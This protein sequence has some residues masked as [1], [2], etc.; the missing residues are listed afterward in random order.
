[1][2]ERLKTLSDNF[3]A[4][5]EYNIHRCM[6]KIDELITAVNFITSLIECD[7]EPRLRLE[8]QKNE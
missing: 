7:S 6:D 5:P 4:N 8:K 3:P 2:I 1:M